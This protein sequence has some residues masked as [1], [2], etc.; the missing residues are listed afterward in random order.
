MVPRNSRAP[1]KPVQPEIIGDFRPWSSRPVTR[2]FL[3]LLV[4]SLRAAVRSR[5]SLLLENLALRQQLAAYAR[6]RKRPQLKPEERSLLKM[7]SL[8]VPSLPEIQ[9]TTTAGTSAI[10][11]VIRRRI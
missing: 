10:E 3:L 11:R 2:F 6:G 5:G 9:M 1:R 7:S 4:W 8:Y